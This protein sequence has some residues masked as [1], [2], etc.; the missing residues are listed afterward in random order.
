[1]C[2]NNDQWCVAWIQASLDCCFTSS[3]LVSMHTLLTGRVRAREGR[4]RTTASSPLSPGSS[5]S[6]KGEKHGRFLS[7]RC[8]NIDSRVSGMLPLLIQVEDES[9]TW[10]IVREMAHRTYGGW[11]SPGL[12][13]AS[14]RRVEILSIWGGDTLHTEMN[15]VGWVHQDKNGTHNQWWDIQ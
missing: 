1:M 12:L 7:L 13:G 4:Q 14:A 9:R 11:T 5:A 3:D 2:N 6:I 8:H 10:G 15:F